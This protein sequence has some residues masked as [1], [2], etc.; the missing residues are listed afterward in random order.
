MFLPS[1]P[2]ET[3]EHRSSLLFPWHCLKVL[4]EPTLQPKIGQQLC[5]H[6][7]LIQLKIQTAVKNKQRRKETFSFFYFQA[8]SLVFLLCLD[9]N[10]AFLLIAN[11]SVG[12]CPS[13]LHS[14][15]VPVFG[16]AHPTREL[17]QADVP[18]V[19]AYGSNYSQCHLTSYRLYFNCILMSNL[20]YF[21][22]HFSGYTSIWVITVIIPV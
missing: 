7:L 1:Q 17:N 18:F 4:L 9:V 13:S 3:L 20:N 21:K 16:C 14:R 12:I 5:P 8:L 10:R 19:G 2:L 15:A 22:W 11:Y 6:C